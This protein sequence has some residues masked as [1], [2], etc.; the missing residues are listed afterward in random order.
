MINY[1][2]SHGQN[3][4]SNLPVC[5]Q[6]ATETVYGRDSIRCYFLLPVAGDLAVLELWERLQTIGVV[7]FACVRGRNEMV[8]TRY[9]ISSLSLGVKQFALAVRSHWSVEN[10]CHW[11]L[12]MT[13]HEEESRIRDER[14]RENS[15]WLNWFSLSLLKQHH[16]KD[17]IVGHVAGSVGLMTSWLEVLSGVVG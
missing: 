9:F 2:D 8:E 13:L 17:R 4:F 3:Y 5:R 16:G 7:T 15:A 14:L 10:A 1:I 11:T 6:T 12:D